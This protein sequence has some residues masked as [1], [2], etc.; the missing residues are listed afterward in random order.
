MNRNPAGGTASMRPHRRRIA[1]GQ[2]RVAE[3]CGGVPGWNPASQ[4]ASY[5]RE[6]VARAML[7]E[8]PQRRED[9]ARLSTRILDREPCSDR[10]FDGP[11]HLRRREAQV[12]GERRVARN[13]PALERESKQNDEILGT[14]NDLRIRLGAGHGGVSLHSLFANSEYTRLC[15]SMQASLG[16]CGAS[17]VVH[18]KASARRRDGV[19]ERCPRQSERP[20]ARALKHAPCAPTGPRVRRTAPRGSRTRRRRGS[21]GT[22]SAAS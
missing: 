16:Q 20:Q 18:A 10:P 5:R 9:H 6:R 17:G 15:A 13:R 4:G 11:V 7:H 21:T 22:G 12:G 3:R 2:D 1:T 8:G 19:L 14:K